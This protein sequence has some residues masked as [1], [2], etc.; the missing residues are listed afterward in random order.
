MVE[1]KQETE[2]TLSVLVVQNHFSF[3]TPTATYVVLFV[4]FDEMLMTLA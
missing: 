2:H 1:P 4:L 3:T